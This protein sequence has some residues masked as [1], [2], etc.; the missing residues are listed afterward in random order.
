MT[1]VVAL[2]GRLDA[3]RYGGGAEDGKLSVDVQRA[4]RALTREVKS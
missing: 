3:S 1:E 4:V 2:F